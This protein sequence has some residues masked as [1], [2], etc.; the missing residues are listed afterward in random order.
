MVGSDRRNRAIRCFSKLLFAQPVCT[1]DDKLGLVEVKGAQSELP[2]VSIHHGHDCR[3]CCSL[4]TKGKARRY[5]MLALYSI[6]ILCYLTSASK[7]YSLLATI[8][9]A[10]SK[11]TFITE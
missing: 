3:A 10:S 6:S 8:G 9:V 7:E 4:T 11:Y 1:D 5:V 2:L